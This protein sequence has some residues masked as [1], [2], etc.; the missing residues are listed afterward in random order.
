M[1][2]LTGDREE[3]PIEALELAADFLIGEAAPVH[4]QKVASSGQ[5]L[6]DS[7]EVGTGGMAGDGK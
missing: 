3:A 2:Q 1:I 5:G 4:L 6:M 7:G